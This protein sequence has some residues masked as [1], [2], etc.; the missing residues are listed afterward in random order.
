MVILLAL[1]KPIKQ[2]EKKYTS[3][4]LNT[5]GKG[6]IEK[7]TIHIKAPKGPGGVGLFIK[8]WLFE[9][10]NID[11]LDN[12]YD[13]ILG[14]LNDFEFVVFSCYLP[15]EKISMEARFV[16]FLHVLLTQI[17]MHSDIESIIICGDFNL[18]LG[19]TQGCN[20]S[21]DE[22]PARIIT[23]NTQTQHVNSLL[24]SLN[25]SRCVS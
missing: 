18:R 10:Y 2:I 16:F 25:D 11:T 24:E 15:P 19:K 22:L 17:Y 23:G 13:G 20:D 7:K 1:L 9:L 14:E 21:T 3:P 8:K 6:Q 4:T 5:S 12:S